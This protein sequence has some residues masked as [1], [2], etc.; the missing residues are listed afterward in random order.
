MLPPPP[1][2]PAKFEASNLTINPRQ[3]QL[4]QP[5]TISITI[6]NEG[7]IA[8]SFELHL[9]I[10]G[11][12]RTVQEVTLSGKSRE[13]LTFEVANLTAGQHQVKIAG[14]GEQFRIIRITT[15]LEGLRINWLIFDVSVGIALI[16]GALILYWVTR[17]AQKRRF[18]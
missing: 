9:I 4:G 17:R 13:T 15:P 7:E 12:V 11:I 8:G 14:L 5:I 2:L 3:P 10:D 16:I 1:P 6:A 18:S